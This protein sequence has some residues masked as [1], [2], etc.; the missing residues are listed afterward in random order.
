MKKIILFFALT[1]LH[2]EKMV[3]A[4]EIFVKGGLG[5]YNIYQESVLQGKDISVDVKPTPLIT[6]GLAWNVSNDLILS[7]E[8]VIRSK[9]FKADYFGIDTTNDQRGIYGYEEIQFLN[10]D[11]KAIGRLKIFETSDFDLGLAIG[12]GISIKLNSTSDFNYVEPKY[13][14]VRDESS[15]TPE[16]PITTNNTGII[17]EIGIDSRY[18]KFTFGIDLTME[19]FRAYLYSIGDN[20]TLLTYF[21]LGYNF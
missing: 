10:L 7:W 1:I 13:M 9:K 17:A 11:V 18:K 6:L 14:L 12:S 19:F 4:Q 16:I 5:F 15:I 3:L 21:T 20:K 8:N 2:P